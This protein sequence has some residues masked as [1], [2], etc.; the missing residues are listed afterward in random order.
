MKAARW[1][2]KTHIFRADEYICSSCGTVS[3]KPYNVCPGCG[4]P[5]KNAKYDA[6]WVDEAEFFSLMSD[7]D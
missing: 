3:D 4:R 5:M 7:D 1:I 2:I 6:S